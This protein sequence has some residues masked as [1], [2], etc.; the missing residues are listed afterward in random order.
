[1]FELAAHVFCFAAIAVWT[2]LLLRARRGMQ[3]TPVVDP[4]TN[5]LGDLPQITAYVPARNE[6]RVIAPCV[7]ALGQ[8]GPLIDRL[9]VID[10]RSNDGT[11]ERLAELEENESRLLVISGD[12]PAPGQCGKPAALKRAVDATLPDRDWL[13]FVDADVVLKP[14]AARGLLALARETK[15]D[16]VTIFPAL[17]LITPIEKL[18]MPS[19][20]ALIAAIYPAEKVADPRDPLAF[21]NGQLIL[22]RRDIYEQIGGHGA[23][24]D[25]ILE[26]VRLAE[27][28]K[29]VDG[30]ICLADG[31]KIARTRM[32]ESWPE[33]VEG[34]S[35][36]LFLLLGSSSKRTLLWALGSILLSA[37][38]WIALAV[39]W[40][41]FG[42]ITFLWIT[43]IQAFLRARGG[44]PPGW[45]LIAPL[46]AIAVAYVLLRSMWL[47][48]KKREVAWKGRRYS[49][50]DQSGDHHQQRTS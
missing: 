29:K 4:I 48:L 43:G 28:V 25:Q 9:I 38:G 33:L 11:K 14:G 7:I 18:V 45:A 1:M 47:H 40:I 36:N 16:L 6:A 50:H 23:V 24:I 44:A 3:R 49:A 22:I 20:G 26:D 17:E 32:Y 30:R 13:L 27:A 21:A 15:A 31:R 46:G 41:P 35:K 19:I 37:L 8:Q 12:G 5:S 10:D 42:L 2:A 34:W 39:A